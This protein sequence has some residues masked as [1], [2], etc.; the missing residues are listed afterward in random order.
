M[1]QEAAEEG[2]EPTSTVHEATSGPQPDGIPAK[3]STPILLENSP[4]SLE[5]PF[6]DDPLVEHVLIATF[7]HHLGPIVEWMYPAL[8]PDGTPQPSSGNTE[9]GNSPKFELPS[10]W[11]TLIPFSALPDGAHSAVG[12]PKINIFHLPPVPAWKGKSFC[13]DHPVYAIAC[14]HQIEV[15]K[16]LVKTEDLK[17]PM[18]QKSVIVLSRI[19]LLGTLHEKLRAITEGYFAELDFSKREL[20]RAA[21]ENMKVTLIT[22]HVPSLILYQELSPAL[23]LNHFPAHRCLKLFKLILLQKRILVYA[24]DVE[25]SGKFQYELLSLFPGFLESLCPKELEFPDTIHKVSPYSHPISGMPIKVQELFQR[26][27]LP[28]PLYQDGAIQPYVPLQQVEELSPSHGIR[29]LLC[30]TTNGIL[31]EMGMTGGTLHLDA[32]LHLDENPYRLEIR[33]PKLINL[34]ALTAP[35]KKFAV[36]LHNL[37]TQHP[38]DDMGVREMFEKYIISL[39]TTL[40]WDEDVSR[41]ESKVESSTEE[42][43]GE[44]GGNFTLPEDPNDPNSLEMR[45]TKLSEFGLEFIQAI[46]ATSWYGPWNSRESAH[47]GNLWDMV[48]PAHPC[49]GHTM[50][51]NLQDRMATKLAEFHVEEKKAA[52]QASLVAAAAKGGKWIGE[53]AAKVREEAAKRQAAHQPSSPAGTQ[54]TELRSAES[55]APLQ[56]SFNVHGTLMKSC[57]WG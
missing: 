21:F 10:E 22:K 46:R 9:S 24:H 3:V 39:L 44:V 50:T 34:I 36:D 48:D 52:L 41:T 55:G 47:A 14:F 5:G 13:G 38:Q 26:A 32:V 2:A 27:G 6:T 4:A 57:F 30:G 12:G 35:D 54:D 8:S 7:H 33:D 16:L 40:S 42:I 15:S 11:A 20:I 37:I 1:G 25:V 19:P 29:G 49:T 18:I 45:R 43:P 17:R 23:F 51:S 53:A 56:S 28:L 31:K